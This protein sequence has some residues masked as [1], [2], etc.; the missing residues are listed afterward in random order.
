MHALFVFMFTDQPCTQ[1]SLCCAAIFMCRYITV[2]YYDVDNKY[3]PL[4][5]FA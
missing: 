4:I 1:V 2:V 3:D 5:R